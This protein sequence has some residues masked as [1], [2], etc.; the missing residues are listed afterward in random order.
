MTIRPNT[1]VR[2]AAQKRLALKIEEVARN[3]AAYAKLTLGDVLSALDAARSRIENGP[4]VQQH[5]PCGA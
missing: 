2:I 1:A 4:A 3:R 5:P